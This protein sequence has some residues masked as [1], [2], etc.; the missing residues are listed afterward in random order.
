M[1]LNIDRVYSCSRDIGIWSEI[2]ADKINWSGVISN[3]VLHH[4][5][6]EEKVS[7][8]CQSNKDWNLI[9]SV[10]SELTRC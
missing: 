9:S 10:S 3:T 6:P 2:T 8:I 1:L 7:V 5:T 4:I